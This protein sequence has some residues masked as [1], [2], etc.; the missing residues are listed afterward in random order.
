M[1]CLIMN[2]IFNNKEFTQVKIKQV[3]FIFCSVYLLLLLH[4]EFQKIQNL[5]EV[6]SNI[7]IDQCIYFFY[8]TLN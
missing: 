1:V 3:H 7:L 6:S 5:N 2:K 4:N 8:V